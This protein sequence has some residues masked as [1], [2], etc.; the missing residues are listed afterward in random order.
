MHDDDKTIKLIPCPDCKG[1]PKPDC[2]KCK[3]NGKIIA[4]T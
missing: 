2:A 1:D 4:G 3:G